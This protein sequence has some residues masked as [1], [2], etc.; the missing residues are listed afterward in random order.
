M[1]NQSLLSRREKEVAALAAQGASNAQI[2]A[3]LYV[4]VRTVESHLYAAFRKL[5]ITRRDQLFD[6][7]R[8]E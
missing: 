8:E 6:A 4:S 7:L 1:P 5:G 2:S 3:E